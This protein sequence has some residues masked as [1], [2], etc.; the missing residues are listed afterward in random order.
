[1]HSQGSLQS[2][3][4]QTMGGN[5]LAGQET[6]L[7]SHK[8]NFEGH[9][10]TVLIHWKKKQYLALL[11]AI[12]KILRNVCLFYVLTNTMPLCMNRYYLLWI[13][14]QKGKQCF[15]REKALPRRS[16]RKYS[17]QGTAV[18]G[19]RVWT[20]P[21]THLCR[22]EDRQTL[23]S[24]NRECFWARRVLSLSFIH[25]S[26]IQQA[27]D[28]RHTQEPMCRA[29]DTPGQDKWGPCPWS[30]QPPPGRWAT[31]KNT[32]KQDNYKWK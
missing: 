13:P 1:M 6:E 12:I 25:H 32:K 24:R 4:S 22:A 18:P 7:K 26:F 21:P 20:V 2:S 17:T 23:R 10:E 29:G 30:S 19:R 16:N 3:V 27:A 28:T 9:D 14:S 31:D 8:I 11:D 15:L 5:P